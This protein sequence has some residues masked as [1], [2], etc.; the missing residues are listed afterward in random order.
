MKHASATISAENPAIITGEV[1]GRTYRIKVTNE[2]QLVQALEL[3]AA[4]SVHP[5]TS[6]DQ[7]R[8][9]EMVRWRYMRVRHPD[10]RRTRHLMGWVGY[11]GRVCSAIVSI[12]PHSRRLTTESGRVYQLV[13]PTGYDSDADWVW[14]RWERYQNFV[15]IS[16]QSNALSR[17]LE[18]SKGQAAS[19]VLTRIFHAQSR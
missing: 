1:D 15:D 6:V 2:A 3:I 17:A 18:K 14:G 4:T 8:V 11:E 10:G 7:E 12:D 9:T 19:D 16:D 5:A 13:G